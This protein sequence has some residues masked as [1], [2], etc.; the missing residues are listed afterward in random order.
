VQIGSGERSE[1]IRTYNFPERRL[2]DHRI[3]FTMY[4]LDKVL[5]GDLDEVLKKL[6][7]EERKK[8]YELQGLV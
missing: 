8:F 1:K 6:I 4:Q 3:N 5:E 7:Q 2:T